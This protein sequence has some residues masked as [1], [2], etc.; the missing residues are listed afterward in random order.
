MCRIRPETG[1]SRHTRDQDY[2]APPHVDHARRGDRRGGDSR[3]LQGLL[4]PSADRPFQRTETADQRDRQP[5]RKAS[6][7]EPPAS[8]RQPQGIPGRDPHRRSLRHGT[9]RTVPFR[10]PGEA[11]PTADPVGKRRRG[12]HPAHCRGRSRPGQGRVPARPRTDRQQG[13]LEKRI[14][15]SRRAVGQDQRHRRRAEGGAGEE[16]R[17]RA[18][19]RDHRHPPG[20]RRRLRL[21]RDADRHLAGPFHPAPGFPPARAGL[22]PAQ[23]RPTGEGPGRRL[24]RPGVRRRDRRHQ[25]QGRQRDPQP[26]GPRCP[27]EPGRQ[28]A[29]GHVRQPRGDVAWRGT[30]RRGAGDGDH[31]HPLRRL[32]LRRR[33]EEGRAG[34]GVEG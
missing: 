20:G 31:L 32:D 16:A 10:R 14:R 28:A 12:S 2:V 6:L 27:G 3:R 4:H 33:A 23:P 17:A 34:P 15:S 26:A 24:P 25:P 22:P 19:R 30:T 5:G 9:R 8:H 29:A 21:A 1:R 18:L 7:A 13:H 11:G